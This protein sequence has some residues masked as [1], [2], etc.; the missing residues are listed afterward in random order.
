MTSVANKMP[1]CKS[2]P[3]RTVN[4]EFTGGAA[5]GV[6]TITSRASYGGH[7]VTIYAVTEFLPD[8]GFD[9][10][11]FRVVKQD[12]EVYSVFVARNGQDHSC[13]CKAGTYGRVKECRHV[14]ALR[15]LIRA[16]RLDDP[17]DDPRR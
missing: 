13:D 2:S 7:V 5:D 17:R 6:M 12:G 1:G 15:A 10:R 9:G 11:A 3:E 14:A 4:Y 16:G 8:S